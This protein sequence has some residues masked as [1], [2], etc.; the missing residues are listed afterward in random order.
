[1]TH[2]WPLLFVV[3]LRGS[4]A[5]QPPNTSA[6]LMTPGPLERKQQ[7]PVPYPDPS[8]SAFAANDQKQIE[9][10]VAHPT[11][12]SRPIGMSNAG[13]AAIHFSRPKF[14][15]RPECRTPRETCALDMCSFAKAR[16]S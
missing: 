9:L 6:T 12:R 14:A 5:R 13:T 16:D 7:C 8:I 4:A 11:M 10:L 1:M 3:T 15:D 2:R